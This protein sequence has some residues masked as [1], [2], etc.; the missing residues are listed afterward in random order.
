[1]KVAHY[2]FCIP[3]ELLVER[4]YFCFGLLF[5]GDND[6]FLIFIV[7]IL[8][9]GPYLHNL[10]GVHSVHLVLHGGFLVFIQVT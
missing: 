7:W 4:P 5:V 9:L 2:D 8:I 10:V 1:M 6:C 3:C